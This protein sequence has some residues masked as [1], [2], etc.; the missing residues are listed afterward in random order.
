MAMKYFSQNKNWNHQTTVLKQFKLFPHAP[1][2]Q[3]AKLNCRKTFPQDHAGAQ[4]ENVHRWILRA[5]GWIHSLLLKSWRRWLQ[6]SGSLPISHSHTFPP[7]SRYQSQS[8]G[9]PLTKVW[10]ACVLYITLSDS[11]WLCFSRQTTGPCTQ[12]NYK[13]VSKSLYKWAFSGETSF[14][15]YVLSK[16]ELHA[17]SCPKRPHCCV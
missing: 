17:P 1:T 14:C 7:H 2:P 9:N 10:I 11:P 12:V 16:H 15:Q 8:V 5:L 3:S 4:T 6:E 13:A